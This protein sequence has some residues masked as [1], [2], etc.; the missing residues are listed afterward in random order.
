MGE[1]TG[2][3]LDGEL[4]RRGLARSR[5]QAA[6]LVAAGRVTR[7]GTVLTKP[8]TAVGPEDLLEVT[9]DPEDPGYVSRAAF[10]LAGVLDALDALGPTG[11]PPRP[12]VVDG[13]RCL[14]L[15]ASTGGFT[16]LL[17]RRGAREV[18]AVDV[19]HD[20]LVPDLRA[21]PRVVV[22]EGLNVRDLAPEHV[23]PVPDLVVGDLSF[24][25]LA[26]VLPAVVGVVGPGTDLLLLVKPQFEVG[27]ERL[28]SGGVVRDPALHVEVVVA[29]ARH[30]AV[31]GLRPLAVVPSPL[32]GPSGNREYFWW[33][34]AGDPGRADGAALEDS[35]LEDAA[36]AAVAWQP[37]SGEGLPP[38]V[39][40]SPTSSAGAAAQPDAATSERPLTGGAA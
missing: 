10:K 8:S 18:V 31:V 38:V 25:S 16:D 4:V 11:A 30:A 37:A 36:A 1:R 3:R 5:R 19:G 22:H 29:V 39:L 24:I 7:E 12:P 27:R 32:P 2:A 35:A 13:A 34:R 17:L 20:Q 21:D 33:L 26:M 28:G 14:D 9:P 15:G 6:D 23:G 40:V